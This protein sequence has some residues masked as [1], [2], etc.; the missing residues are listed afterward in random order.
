[1]PRRGDPIIGMNVELIEFEFLFFYCLVNLV[2]SFFGYRHPGFFA[3]FLWIRGWGDPTCL[4]P[5]KFISF[6]RILG[7]LGMGAAVISP[8]VYLV[9]WAT[10]MGR[11]Q[12]P[13]AI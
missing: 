9:M 5:S 7:L 11:S 4:P 10:G 6:V 13:P 3:K 12:P 1:M 2:F 8:V